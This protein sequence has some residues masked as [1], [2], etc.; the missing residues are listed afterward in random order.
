MNNSLYFGGGFFFCCC[1][2]FSFFAEKMW[3]YFD[4]FKFGRREEIW[5]ISFFSFIL[6]TNIANPI[7]LTDVALY[8]S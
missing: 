2:V 4:S 6:F 5:G 1:F 8:K 7:C 3:K